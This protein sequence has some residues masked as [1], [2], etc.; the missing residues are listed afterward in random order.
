MSDGKIICKLCEG[1]TH[2]IELHLKEFHKD[3]TIASYKEKFP[4]E[5]ILSVMA[6]QKLAEHWAAKSAAMS[7]TMMAT[8]ALAIVAPEVT[9]KDFHTLFGFGEE[10]AALSS[11]GK[12]IKVTIVSAAKDADL[13]PL[14]DEEYIFDIAPLKNILMGIELNIPTYVWGHAGVG[15]TSLYEQIAAR[16]KRPFLRVQHTINTEEAHILGQWTVKGGETVYQLGPLPM[17]ML[18]GWVYC[19]DEYDFALPSVLSVYQAVLEGKPLVIKDAP[20]EFRIISPSANFRI[21]ATGNTN[22]GGDETGLYQGTQIQNSANY[23]RFGIVEQIRYMTEEQEV[24]IIVSRAKIAASDAAKLVQ[25][26]KSVRDSYEKAS[27][28]STISPRSLIFAAKLGIRRGSFRIGINLA[29]TNRLNK[30]DREV[31]DA[32]AQR[33]F[34]VGG[35]V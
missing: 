16:T 35:A 29:F 23:E 14:V 22:G 34:G 11:S 4:N 2:S 28:S 3:E 33:L 25:F 1:H 9:Q 26:A 18:N 31:I 8:S 17:A 20:P 12:P 24:K 19:A 7:K 27:I 10:K 15:K 21:V 30:V 32:V 6:T 13:V 5:P